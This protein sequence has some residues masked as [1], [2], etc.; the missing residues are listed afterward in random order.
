MEWIRMR[1]LAIKT[2]NSHS[3]P[4]KKIYIST[5]ES[6]WTIFG[7]TSDICAKKRL[8]LLLLFLR[9]AYS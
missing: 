3:V 9:N 8:L 4:Q 1:Y 7:S 5:E 6:N 2:L